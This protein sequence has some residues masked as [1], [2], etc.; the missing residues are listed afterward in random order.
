MTRYDRSYFR[1]KSRNRTRCSFVFAIFPIFA[2]QRLWRTKVFPISRYP[3]S[4]KVSSRCIS[5]IISSA[6][7]STEPRSI[8]RLM[9]FQSRREEHATLFSRHSRYS[10]TLC[11]YEKEHGRRQLGNLRET[12]LVFLPHELP[13]EPI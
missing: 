6:I 1:D 7:F 10:R 12:S 5:R 9:T 8:E 4:T 11:D 3:L 13:H 2:S